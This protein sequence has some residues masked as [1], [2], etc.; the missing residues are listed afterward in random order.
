[1]SMFKK[2]TRPTP[3]G[4]RKVQHSGKD[5]PHEVVWPSDYCSRCRAHGQMHFDT[6]R[7]L[8][9]VCSERTVVQ[10]ASPVGLHERRQRPEL[11]A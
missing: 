6:G 8:C 7:A 11:E 9:D 2:E 5:L 3:E 4:W 10:L 1:M